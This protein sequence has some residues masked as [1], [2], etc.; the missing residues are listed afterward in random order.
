MSSQA[1]D[2]SDQDRMED[3]RSSPDMHSLARLRILYGVVFLVA[4]G[5][6][7]IEMV[8]SPELARSAVIGAAVWLVAVALADL[9]SVPVWGSVV[10]SLSF[11]LLIAAGMVFPPYVAGAIALL[12]TGEP[13]EWKREISIG[14]AVFNRSHIA[15]ATMTASFVFHGLNGDP[16]QWPLVLLTTATALSA[17]MVVNLALVVLAVRM[18]TRLSVTRIINQVLLGRPT[19]RIIDYVSVGLMAPVMA[20][21]YLEVGAWGL[22]SVVAPVFL[23]HQLF[24]N[25]R[26]LREASS[27][28]SSKSRALASTVARIA[29]ERRQERVFVAGDLHDEVLQPL[30]KVH[31][32]GQVLRRDLETG[33]LLDL[34]Q[35]LPGL[36]EA[37]ESAQEAIRRLLRDLRTSS[38]G[39]GGL[40]G[41][42]RLLVRENEEQTGVR[43]RMN[44][45]EVEGSALSELVLFQVARES[46]VNVEKHSGATEVSIELYREL[47]TICLVVRDNGCGFEPTLVDRTAHFG[48]QLARE[49][50]EAIDGRLMIESHELS[51]TTVIARVPVSPRWTQPE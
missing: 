27:A 38:L 5:I 13:R 44:V 26:E 51:G 12:G 17:D 3:Q 30:Y 29:E 16:R 10:F 35:D 18:S 14:K 43:F 34:D 4:A 33:R 25:R 42:L 20:I 11:P 50:V 23:A 15:L 2:D 1:I 47:D 45:Q 32:M 41:T 7:T 8:N 28:V 40:V 19:R 31:L 6:L 9:L 37:T 48:L 21:L 39:V 24:S 36:L 22:L 49:R 46:V